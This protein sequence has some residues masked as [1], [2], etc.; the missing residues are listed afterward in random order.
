M[1]MKFKYLAI[2]F[3]IVLQWLLPPEKLFA[4]TQKLNVG[5]EFFLENLL[6]QVPMAQYDT[7]KLRLY[8]EIYHNHYNFDTIIKYATLAANLA[9][10]LNERKFRAE[11]YMFIGAIYNSQSKN[12]SAEIFFRLSL[13]YW[14]EVKDTTKMAV[15]YNC[16]AVID[17][18]RNFYESA[19]KNYNLA[20]DLFLGS[21]DTARAARIYRGIANTYTGFNVQQAAREYAEKALA[22]DT[23]YE[24]VMAVAFDLIYLGNAWISDYYNTGEVALL[25]SAKKYYSRGLAEAEKSN[26]LDVVSESSLELQKLFLETANISSGVKFS[27]A[28]DSSLIYKALS[29]SCIA[30]MSNKVKKYVYDINECKEFVLTGRLS[31]AKK[32]IDKY[33]ALFLSDLSQYENLYYENLGSVMKLYYQKLADYKALFDWNEKYLRYRRLRYNI[34]FATG[35]EFNKRKESFVKRGKEIEEETVKMKHEFIHQRGQWR[36][37]VW[38]LSVVLTGLVLIMWILRKNYVAKVRIGEFLEKQNEKILKVNAELTKIQDTIVSQ[39]AEIQAQS[40]KIK[41][42]NAEISATN[43]AV[44]HSIEYAGQI[45]TASMPQQSDIDLWFKD[46]FLIYNPLEIVSGDF[47]WMGETKKFRIL[48]VFDCT[49]HGIPGGLLSMLGISTLNDT[50][51]NLAGENIVAAV[52]NSLRK[53]ILTAT[54]EDIYDGTDGAVVAISKEDNTLHIAGA[55]RPVWIIRDGK[56]LEF[57]PDRMSIGRDKRQDE[58]FT[59]YDFKYQ[60]DD[61]VYMFTDGV[62]DV[63]GYADDGKGGEKLLKFSQ[64]RLKA[65]LTKIEDLSFSEQKSV[66]IKTLEDWQKGLKQD[67]RVDDQLMIGFRL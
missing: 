23:R 42:Q 66:I 27:A 48:G 59:G 28:I 52:L 55:M 43:L 21:G 65:L 62:T 47:Y 4:Q 33:S 30:K 14:Q 6:K 58:D 56:L 61:K 39:T 49:G 12:D 44:I 46:N 3:L 5:D 2:Y 10:K 29:K 20:L 40:Q 15:S 57:F 1:I 34:T 37:K 54:S 41:E 31:E 22:I 11:A 8:S 53:K 36:I 24:D 9:E 16:L 60:R 25:D 19:I 64:K 51:Q 45:Q 13:P 35:G 7:T 32:I 63:F 18:N 38:F 26:F 17:E 67:T 50:Q